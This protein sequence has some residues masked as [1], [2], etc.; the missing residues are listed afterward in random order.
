MRISVVVSTL[1]LSNGFSKLLE[2]LALQTHPAHE[3]IVV[4]QGKGSEVSDLVTQWQ[5]RLPIRR[6]TSSLGVSLGRNTG[7]RELGECEVV[8]FPDDDCAYDA[9]GLSM[10]ALEFEAE[11]LVALSGRLTGSGNRIAFDGTRCDIDRRSVWTKAIEATTMYRFET[12]KELSGFDEDLGIGSR[13]TWQSG[14]GTDLLL[15]AISSGG[16]AV[17]NPSIVITEH[18]QPIS[19]EQYLKKARLYARG[20]GRVYRTRYGLPAQIWTVAKPLGAACVLGLSGK[21]NQARMKWQV[22]KGRVEGLISSE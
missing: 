10:V 6:L 9:D 1:G 16:R 8:A 20:T 3:V 15:R 18:Q 13:T 19:A 5:D 4:D 21:Q 22:F 2:S 12:L 7:W 14:E 17:Y 11:D